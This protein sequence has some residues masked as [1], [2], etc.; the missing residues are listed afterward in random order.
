MYK[1]LPFD[2]WI[3]RV[4]NK[5][6]KTNEE[7]I[8]SLKEEA[9]VHDIKMDERI[10]D[11]MKKV[12]RKN[13]VGSYPYHTNSIPVKIFQGYIVP[14]SAPYIQPMYAH[15]L[16]LKKEDRV[17]EIGTG[18][19]YHAC[20]TA[21]LVKEVV[22]MEFFPEVAE[23]GIKNIEKHKGVEGT[24]SDNITKIDNITVVQGNGSQGYKEKAPYDKIYFTTA[25][26]K[27]MKNPLIEQLKPDGRLVYPTQE[28]D[29]FKLGKVILFENNTE[30]KVS[31]CRFVWMK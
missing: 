18:S 19:G 7:M 16:D 6:F 25:V 14:N 15:A 1:N 17:L 27:N 30:Y 24:R 9:Y 11:A 12:D 10:W 20:I 2:A 23:I 3:G 13:F 21:E 28:P 22:T 8:I 31:D 29:R 26:P 4:R 5:D